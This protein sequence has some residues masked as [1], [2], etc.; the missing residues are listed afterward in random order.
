M[1]R[2][3]A[4]VPFVNCLA[5]AEVRLVQ[6]ASL[7]CREARFAQ[8]LDDLLSEKSLLWGNGRRR[9]LPPELRADVLVQAR[10]GAGDFVCP[11]VEVAYLIEQ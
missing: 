6:S 10:L 3:S 4:A 8:R 1:F 2:I 7:T 9:S 5:T 11:A